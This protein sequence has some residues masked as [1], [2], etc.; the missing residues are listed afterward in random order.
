MTCTKTLLLNGRTLGLTVCP[1]VF[2][3]CGS[4]LKFLTRQH[5]LQQTKENFRK[6][7]KYFSNINIDMIYGLP[8]QTLDQWQKELDTLLELNPQHASLYLLTYASGTPIGRAQLRGKI[9][10]S[11]DK[12]LESFLSESQRKFGQSWL[13]T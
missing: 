13:Y 1:L 11:E 6:A 9:K 8:S 3:L 2:S 5:S 7:Q 4:G 12:V 10:S